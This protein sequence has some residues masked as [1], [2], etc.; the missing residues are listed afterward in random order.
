MFTD[1][2]FAELALFDEGLLQ[3]FID[4]REAILPA[5]EVAIATGWIG[6]PLAL[7]DVLEARAG[8]GVSL[9]NTQT[10]EI[11]WVVELTAS[12]DIV[13]GEQVMARLLPTGDVVRLGGPIMRV[14]LRLRESVVALTGDPDTTA[15]DW[16]GWIG[17]TDA[18]PVIQNREGEPTVMCMSRFA[19]P[20]LA[21]A[22]QALAVVLEPDEDGD[23]FVQTIELDGEHDIRGWVT[24]EG[25]E[26]V[27]TTN[28]IARGDR[29]TALVR[30]AIDGAVLVDEAT[31][32]QAQIM[33]EL[34][35]LDPT[36]VPTEAAEAAAQSLTQYA[37]SWVDVAIPALG[38]MS[39]RQ[40]MDDPTRRED[41]MAILREF[42]QHEHAHPAW[43]GD[44]PSS[45]ARAELGLD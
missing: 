13:E 38:G 45:I 8:A 4:E 21:A 10:R 2:R 23:L 15:C 30:E 29:L 35:E 42:E 39:P 43:T 37:R 17:A 3:Q 28:S 27:V 12:G 25:D 33:R 7:H 24:I 34:Q 41:L 14:P 1:R 5:D 20:D 18:P 6:R 32:T 40:A 44:T 36:G 26:V 19:V 9:R 31:R 11:S 22:R 16:A